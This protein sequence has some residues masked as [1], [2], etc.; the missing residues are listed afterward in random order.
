M[1]SNAWPWVWSVPQTSK[2]ES[3]RRVIEKHIVLTAGNAPGSYT[4]VCNVSTEG[5]KHSRKILYGVDVSF[6]FLCFCFFPGFH[7]YLYSYPISW[8]TCSSESRFSKY[9][10]WTGISVCKKNQKPANYQKDLKTVCVW[11]ISM[12]CFS[13]NWEKINYPSHSI[14]I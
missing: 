8:N 9:L 7:S 1:H 3:P 10:H 2:G 12:M 5:V 14:L 6:L 4:V 11:I 13:E